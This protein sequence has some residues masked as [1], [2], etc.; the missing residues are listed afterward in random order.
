MY[1]QKMCNFYQVI[2]LECK[3]KWGFAAENK[4]TIG[5]RK[6]KFDMETDENHTYNYVLTT[7]SN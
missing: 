5:A 6:V 2:F 1:L 3:T 7:L 4:R